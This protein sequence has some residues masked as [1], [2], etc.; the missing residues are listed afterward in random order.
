M[1]L[2]RIALIVSVGSLAALAS[3]CRAQSVITEWTF[4]NLATGSNQAPAP[5]VDTTGTATAVSLG[6]SSTG[7]NSTAGATG[8]D[9]SNIYTLQGTDASAGNT[10][11]TNSTWRI[12]GTNGW[13]SA[14]A[15]GTQ[16]AQFDV[17]T[18]GESNI[19]LSF[20]ISMSVQ[21]E[22][23]LQVQ[24]TT[25][26]VTWNNAALSYGGL[27][28]SILTNSSVS[29]L[30]NG[31][32]FHGSP[33]SVDAWFNGITANFSGISA[34]NNDPNFAVRIVNASTGASDVNLKTNTAINNTSGNWRLDDV[35]FTGTAIP[36]PS[37]WALLVGCAA[38]AAAAVRRRPAV[39]A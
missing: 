20:D 27:G 13:N 6:M 34:V 19:S 29:T 14:A 11:S 23:N 30:V 3:P 33:S 26:G 8:P 24:Y 4:D 21:A 32:Y 35:T 10:S 39:S 2:S 22:A 38:L 1:N 7:L 15:I 25:D 17:S 28:A 31:T 16:G 5:S 36:E 12:V 37:S 9:T 18:A